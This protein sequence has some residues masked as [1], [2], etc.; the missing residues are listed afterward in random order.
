M[1]S[2]EE[3]RRTCEITHAA[4]EHS[5]PAPWKYGNRL[6]LRFG[7]AS[8]PGQMEEWEAWR[9]INMHAENFFEV[10][11]RLKMSSVEVHLIRV[12]LQEFGHPH[13]T[14]SYA[15]ITDARI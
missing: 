4:F 7:K 8:V 14:A 1:V 6:K 13:S 9:V 2:V 12:K 5:S 3:A 10:A 11:S 15:V